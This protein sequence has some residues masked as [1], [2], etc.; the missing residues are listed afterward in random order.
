MY[1][2]FSRNQEVCM[3]IKKNYNT[4]WVV[5][6]LNPTTRKENIGKP[7]PANE[8]I[9]IKH[10]ATC[11]L[12]ASDNV[13]YRNDFGLEYEVCVHSFATKNKSQ[14][15]ALES[16]GLISPDAPTKFQ[17]DQNIWMFCTSNDPKDAEEIEG[18]LTYTAD[19]L[20]A[21]IKKKLLE[22]GSYGIRGL[23]R[24]FKIL[25]DDGGRK[26]D[27]KEFQNGLL[28]YGFSITDE[29]AQLLLNK[30]DTNKDGHVDFDEFMRY[31]KGDINEFR[32]GFIR[33][34]YDKLDK[35]KDGQVTLEDIAMIYDASFHP[36]VLSKN[37]TPEEVYKEFMSQWDTQV[38][39][40][41]VTFDEFMEYFKDVSASIDSDEYFEVMIRNAWK[42]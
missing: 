36:D 34:A 20:I 42:I 1:A 19:D 29:Q 13:D 14:N 30:F 26:L 32:E 3:H 6:D 9:V 23:A 5:E 4:V 39:D 37:K 16:S 18:E 27:L 38:A 41:I 11:H 35:N 24:I 25:D 21:D 28:D 40:G 31:L 17:H 12:L 22:R 8:P 7:I 33:Q 10:A 15:L 2:R